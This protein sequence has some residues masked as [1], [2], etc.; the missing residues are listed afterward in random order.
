MPQVWKTSLALDYDLPASFPLSVTI[1][2]IFTKTINGVMLQNWDLK[3]PDDTWQRFSGPDDRY[4]YPAYA[5]LAYNKKN[6]YVLTNT[7][8]GWGRNW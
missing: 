8:E 2:G 3:E 4:I 5:D 6:S 7:N 1:E